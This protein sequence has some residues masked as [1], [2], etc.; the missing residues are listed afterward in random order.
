MYAR[1]ANVHSKGTKKGIFLPV[2]KGPKARKTRANMHVH[3]VKPAKSSF[4]T[5][6]NPFRIERE[7]EKNF[8]K[9]TQKCPI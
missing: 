1:E 4:G 7:R 9:F 3:G 6:R 8:E 5:V 2:M